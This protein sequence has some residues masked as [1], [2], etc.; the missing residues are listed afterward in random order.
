M[1]APCP[2]PRSV[3]RKPALI[4][5]KTMC[6]CHFHIIGSPDA[7]PFAPQRSYTP[8]KADEAD[9]LRMASTLGIERM[10]VVQPSVYGLDNRC[11]LDAIDR[12]GRERTRGVVLLGAE[13]DAQE[14]RRLHEAGVRGVRFITF[15][16]GSA[17]LDDLKAVAHKI[18]DFG[19]HLQ[20]YVGP[21]HL[22]DLIPTLKDLPVEIVFDHL[23]AVKADRPET[24]AALTAVLGLLDAGRAWVKLTSYRSSVEG[25]PYRDANWLVRTYAERAPDRCLWGSDWPHPHMSGFMPDDGDLLDLLLD[26]VPDQRLLDRILADNPARLYGFGD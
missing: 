5:P 17:S 13:V 9:Y 3:T 7:Y 24:D 2:P 11:T 4:A 20:I 10:V 18:A 16:A 22:L 12:L 6:D 8:P 26:C 23:G 19:W 25:A 15:A 14:L 21:E 1:T